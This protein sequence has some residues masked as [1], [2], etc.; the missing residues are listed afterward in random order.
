MARFILDG[1]GFEMRPFGFHMYFFQVKNVAVVKSH[2][3]QRRGWYFSLSKLHRISHATLLT[4]FQHSSHCVSHVVV[5]SFDR[6]KTRPNF[7]ISN[8]NCMLEVQSHPYQYYC[9]R[10]LRGQI[11]GH[12]K[13]A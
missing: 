8:M 10:V 6:Y 13:M 1:S 3:Y 12:L 2:E 5:L 11:M 9:I 7:H 4:D